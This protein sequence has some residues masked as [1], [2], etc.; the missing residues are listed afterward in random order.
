MD[1]KKFKRYKKI[2]LPGTAIGEF[3]FL[4]LAIRFY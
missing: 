1:M 3:Y 2:N 4:V